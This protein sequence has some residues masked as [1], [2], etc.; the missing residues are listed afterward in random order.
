MAFG[1]GGSTKVSPVDPSESILLAVCLRAFAGALIRATLI[2]AGT[3]P[4][5]PSESF[6]SCMTQ[7]GN[8]AS[9][10]SA[11]GGST[12]VPRRDQYCWCSETAE[13]RAQ[14]AVIT[15]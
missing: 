8:R 10:F 7:G 1:G 12:V 3:L 6:G 4:C 13:F 9:G 14:R 5:R 15:E 11:P 2:P